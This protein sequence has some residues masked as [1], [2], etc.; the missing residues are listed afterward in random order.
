MIAGFNQLIP[1]CVK[2]GVSA[3]TERGKV[4]RALTRD[5]PQNTQL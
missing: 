1:T 2:L 3:Y 4:S 5:P